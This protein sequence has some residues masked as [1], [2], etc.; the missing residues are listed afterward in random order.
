MSKELTS[1]FSSQRIKS[2]WLITALIILMLASTMARDITRPFIGLHSWGQ[3]HFAWVARSHI[4]YGLDYTKGF[5]TFAVG[6]TPPEEKSWYLDHPTL[7]T[8]L[9]SLT[10][11]TFGVNSWSLRI[12]DIAMTCLTLLLFIKIMRGLSN[13]ITALLAGLIWAICPLMGYFG[14]TVWVYP[15]A[16][17]SI[18]SYMTI[19]GVFDPASVVKKWHWWLLGISLFLCI[20]TAWEG[21]FWAMAIGIHYVG[22]CLLK[23]KRLNW[24]LFTILAVAPNASVVLNFVILGAGHHWDFGRLIELIKIRGGAGERGQHNW[25]AWFKRVWEFAVL[26][27]TNPVLILS[28]GYLLFGWM[29]ILLKPSSSKND[30]VISRRFPLFFFWLMPPVFQ[31]FIL[32]GTL[33][34]HQYWERPMTPLVAISAAL[35]ILVI[36]DLLKKIK[37]QLAVIWL[38]LILG[39]IAGFCIAGTNYYYAVRWQ[40]PEKIEMFE[41]L[42]EKIP[43][44]KALLSFDP[45]IIDQFPGVKESSYR[46]EIAWYLDREIDVAQKLDD[47]IAKTA[48]GKYQFYLIPRSYG[49]DPKTNQYLANI[50]SELVKRYSIMAYVPQKASKRTKDGKF[51]RAGMPAYYIFDLSKPKS[52]P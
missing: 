14:V 1:V 49:N 16:F 30:S 11:V 24:K 12:A 48:T 6:S 4:A 41:M 27:Y 38:I 2:F 20:Q 25:D 13:D 10:M 19:I 29:F 8:L 39:L 44:D 50:I 17:L 32:K 47:I 3:S 52:K 26:N 35:G 18:W 23:R 15:L 43:S 42:R 5:D 28:I 33:W 7:Y 36:F 51:L 46:P 34:P 37:F 22:Y 21:F 40:E 9:D 45:F 31:L